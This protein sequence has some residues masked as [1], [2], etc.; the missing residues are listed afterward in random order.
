M[1]KIITFVPILFFL[2]LFAFNAGVV[3]ASTCNTYGNTTYCSDGTTYNTYGNT[4][5]GSD[6]TTYNTYG[7]TTYV[8]GSNGYSGTANTYGNTTYYNGTDGDNWTANTYGNTTYVNGSNGTSGTINTYGGTSYGD[9]NVFNTC[10]TNS[11]Y[12]S[13]AGNCKCNSSYVASGSSCV[14][15]PYI[16]TYTPTIGTYSNPI[17]VESTEAI[18]NSTYQAQERQ[19]A[20]WRATQ[21][22]QMDQFW[23]KGFWSS[24][25]IAPISVS[26]DTTFRDSLDSS[27]QK[28]F[29]VNSMFD[30]SYKSGCGCKSGYSWNSTVTA[31]VVSGA[32][33]TASVSGC[34]STYGFSPTTGKSCSGSVTSATLNK[35]EACPHLVKGT[36]VLPAAPPPN[37]SSWVAPPTC[38]CR[39]GY[40]TDK[41][42]QACIQK[43]DT[44][45]ASSENEISI[46]ENSTGLISSTLRKG[47]SGNE[48]RLLQAV[49]I[50]LGYMQGDATGYFGPKT[51]EAVIKYQTENGLEAVGFTGPKTR[52]LLNGES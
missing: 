47:A 40:E 23:G 12:D 15:K 41:S 16:S 42:G 49:L 26:K 52:V 43:D 45:Q 18:N 33:T 35:T 17:Y 30:A 19:S 27:C 3:F 44:S 39:I 2:T 13:L 8:N 51:K 22:A 34:T 5:Y 1:K 25:N 28:S 38:V 4:T 14:Y 7:N 9:G 48:V 32:V 31:C 36:R 21:D 6:G 20:Q 37:S 24:S 50:R 29:G 10:P 46:F 11:T